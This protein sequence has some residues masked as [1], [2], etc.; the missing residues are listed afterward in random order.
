MVCTWIIRVNCLTSIKLSVTSSK[1]A[2]F[3]LFWLNAGFEIMWFF[4]CSSFIEGSSVWSTVQLN[5][6]FIHAWNSMQNTTCDLAW[7]HALW[8]V[9][10]KNSTENNPHEQKMLSPM[11]KSFSAWFHMIL[12]D[13]RRWVMLELSITMQNTI[14]SNAGVAPVFPR[15]FHSTNCMDHLFPRTAVLQS[16]LFH[17]LGF[18]RS[19]VLYMHGFNII[20]RIIAR[21]HV[22]VK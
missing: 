20:H 2:N 1:A 19:C 22:H 16:L 21:F 9:V 12:R 8:S 3:A 6:N 7:N 14:L 10:N 13:Y 18:H 15:S 4:C 11:V 5:Y 17:N